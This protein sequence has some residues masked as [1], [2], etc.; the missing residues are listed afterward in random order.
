MI[1]TITTPIDPVC[2]MAVHPSA[3]ISLRWRGRDYRFC[4]SACRDTFRDDPDR[5]AEP[6]E[7]AEHPV[8]H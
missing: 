6:L 2:G 4:E 3:G 1:E 7:H 8:S 5:W